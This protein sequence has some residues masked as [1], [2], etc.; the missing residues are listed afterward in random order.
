MK[1][2]IQLSNQKWTVW[3]ILVFTILICN[4]SDKGLSINDVM[5]EV[6]TIAIFSIG[7]HDE[8]TRKNMIYV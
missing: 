2:K 1:V 7:L 3:D 8:L 4:N 5:L 6:G